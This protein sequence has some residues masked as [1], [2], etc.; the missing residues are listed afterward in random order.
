MDKNP[1]AASLA[2]GVDPETAVRQET[3]RHA[4]MK[5]IT[6][7]YTKRVLDVRTTVLVDMTESGGKNPVTLVMHSEAFDDLGG[8]SGIRATMASAFSHDP[9]KIVI[10]DGRTLTW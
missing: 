1:S 6:C 9:E 2:G 10:T 5:N 8:T 7:P 3:L 4:V